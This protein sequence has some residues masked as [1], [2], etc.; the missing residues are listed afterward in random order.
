MEFDDIA[1]VCPV[2]GGPLIYVDGKDA[3][4]GSSRKWICQ[5]CDATGKEVYRGK[6]VG[7]Q[8][9]HLWDGRQVPPK[10]A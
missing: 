2:C 6:F 10:E 4:D 7:H 1:G 3:L 5:D 9:V 8:D